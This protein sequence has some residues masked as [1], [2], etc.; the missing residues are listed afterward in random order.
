[1]FHI[2]SFTLF[3]ITL[4]LALIGMIVFA[5]FNNARIKRES[6]ELNRIRANMLN[7]LPID[8][9]EKLLANKQT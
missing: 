7:T 8:M 2:D 3:V 1:M 4:G 5:F 9:R 6:R